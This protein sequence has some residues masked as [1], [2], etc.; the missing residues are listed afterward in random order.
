VC[1]SL[2]VST[3]DKTDPYLARC[4]HSGEWW[5]VSIADS[6]GD[7]IPGANTQA[8]RLD[9]VE[10]LVKEVVSILLDVDED[11]V[12]V[13]LEVELPDDV[14]V[15]VQGARA[16]RSA[17]EQAQKEASLAANRAAVALVKR[18]GLTV[19][20]AGRVLGLSHQRVDQL[21]NASS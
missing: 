13:Q 21:L 10:G 18:Q 11:A 2:F 16:L 4:S 14:R 15:E 1:Y 6:H 8:R 17:A 20:E 12:K 19:R 5:A 3:T 7:H 9:Q